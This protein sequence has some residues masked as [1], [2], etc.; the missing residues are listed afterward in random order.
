MSQSGIGPTADSRYSPCS[1]SLWHSVF[2]FGV[3]L[4]TV[5]LHS[6]G[7]RSRS[8][9]LPHSA[10]ILDAFK[11]SL[12]LSCRYLMTNI[13]TSH[14][15]AKTAC[16]LISRSK[17]SEDSASL[18]NCFMIYPEEKPTL[19]PSMCQLIWT[20]VRCHWTSSFAEEKISKLIWHSSNIWKKP[21]KILTQRTTDSVIQSSKV[22]MPWWFLVSTTRSLT[23]SSHNLLVT[24]SKR[25]L[26]LVC[27][28]P[29]IS[30]TKNSTTTCHFSWGL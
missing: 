24:I 15:A 28:K 19:S 27:F 7:A 10:L 21:S 14:L 17:T 29:Y 2:S 9:L 3:K 5:R 22:R 25:P 13:I 23:K 20:D 26:H 11:R 12:E 18:R 4:P 1:F 6:I 30:P 16:T 8:S